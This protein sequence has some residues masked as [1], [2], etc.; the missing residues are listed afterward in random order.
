MTKISP[1][2]LAFRLMNLKLFNAYIRVGVTCKFFRHRLNL[3]KTAD[4]REKRSLWKI[5]SSL[6]G[7]CMFIWFFGDGEHH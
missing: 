4:Q 6:K 2:S 5:L 3:P 7:I 1:H